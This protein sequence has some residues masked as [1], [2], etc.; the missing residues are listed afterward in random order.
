MPRKEHHTRSFEKIF[1]QA[2]IVGAENVILNDAEV[3]IVLAGGGTPVTASTIQNRRWIGEYNDLRP[4]DALG[5]L[6]PSVYATHKV[7]NPALQ[8]ST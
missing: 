5:G 4:H 1:K 7:E 8:P 2:A 6:S 3:G